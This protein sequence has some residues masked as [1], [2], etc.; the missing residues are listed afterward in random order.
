MFR[1]FLLLLFFSLIMERM[2]TDFPSINI[3]LD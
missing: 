2:S 1:Y 3:G